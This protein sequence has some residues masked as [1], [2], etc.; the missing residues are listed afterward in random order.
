[1]SHWPATKA[2]RVLAALLRIGWQIKRQSSSHRTLARPGWPDYVFAFHDDETQLFHLHAVWALPPGDEDFS[3][4]WKRIKADFTERWLASGGAEMRVTPSQ[5]R[6]GNR[7]VWQRRFM[8]H[9]IRD[10]IDLERHCD[11]IHY[12]PV[13]HG[14]VAR[15]W[16]WPYSSFRRF[17]S[18]GH[19]EPDWGRWQP[20]SLV[21]LDSRFYE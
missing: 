5:A 12:N 20:Q 14:L 4:R 1:M 8:E 17:V 16:D 13:K 6:R 11:Y 21:T 19:Y 7:G 9:L 2:R 18:L 3:S 10:E 15:P